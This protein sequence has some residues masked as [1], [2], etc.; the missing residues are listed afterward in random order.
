M[1]KT[2]FWIVGGAAAIYILGRFAFLKKA[3][4]ILS[5]IKPGGSITN[6]VIEIG[7]IVQNPTNQKITVRSIA[8]SLYV[9]SELVGYLNTNVSQVIQAFGETPLKLRMRPTAIGVIKTL[10]NL[11]KK[12]IPGTV[13]RFEGSAN[14]DG[15]NIPFDQSQTL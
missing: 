7:L 2:L 3:N 6:P 9:N 5:S 12:P 14:V 13:V 10:I 4:F 8:G 15:I 11:F 1:K